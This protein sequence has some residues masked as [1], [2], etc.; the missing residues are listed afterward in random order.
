M[1]TTLIIFVVALTA[2]ASLAANGCC[3]GCGKNGPNLDVIPGMK[4][5]GVPDVGAMKEHQKEIEQLGKEIQALGEEQ[6]RIVADPTLNPQ[7]KQ[8]R[9]LEVQKQLEPKLKRMA[10]LGGDI[11]NKETEVKKNMETWD[12]G[13]GGK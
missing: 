11:M 3:R 7:E 2:L 4:D 1:K 13:K 10:E 8:R 6:Q 9:I 5:S 12:R